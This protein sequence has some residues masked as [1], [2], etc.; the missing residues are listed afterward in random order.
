MSRRDASTSTARSSPSMLGYTG[1]DRRR[2]SSPT[3]RQ[4][5]SARRSPRQVRRRGRVRDRSSAAPTARRRSRRTR[6]AGRSRTSRRPSQARLG[7]LPRRSRSTPTSSCSRRRPSSGAMRA[8][9]LKRGVVI[10]ENPQTGEI[11][12]MVQ[13]A[14]PTT[15]TP[16]PGHAATAY[17]EAPRGPEQAA[18]EL[19]RP[20][21]ASRPGR[22]TS[23]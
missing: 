1:A 19:R 21:A 11:L 6:R 8:A 7:R 4:G 17:A 9:G 14:E 20:G 12:A 15:T 5:L 13:P 22:R 18:P 10:V 16:S 2:T 23:S 3:S